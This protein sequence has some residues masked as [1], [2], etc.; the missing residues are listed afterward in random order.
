MPTIADVNHNDISPVQLLNMTYTGL[1]H[2]HVKEGVEINHEEQEMGTDL[3]FV[4]TPYATV[5]GISF[6]RSELY[7]N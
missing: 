1:G 3:S 7:T 5:S 2:P 4:I 6:D